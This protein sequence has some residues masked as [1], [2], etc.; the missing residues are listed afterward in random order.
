MNIP[1]HT[2]TIEEVT[3]RK[4]KLACS[5]MI[6]NAVLQDAT[7]RIEDMLSKDLSRGILR[8]LIPGKTYREEH[9]MDSVHVPLTWWDHFKA[10]RGWKHK[11]REITRT[12]ITDLT[13][14]CPHLNIRTDLHPHMN[15]LRVNDLKGTME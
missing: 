14:V 4:V 11:T 1:D 13:K 7:F 9:D 5:H 6:S 2:P 10:T 8:M 3:L 15:F 12:N